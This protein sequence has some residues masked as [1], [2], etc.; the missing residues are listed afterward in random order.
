MDVP[1]LEERRLDPEEEALASRKS[2]TF[3]NYKHGSHHSAEEAT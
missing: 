2:N 3:R 1:E